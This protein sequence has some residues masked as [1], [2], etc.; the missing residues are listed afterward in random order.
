MDRRQQALKMKRAEKIRRRERLARAV[1]RLGSLQLVLDPQTRH[2]E[3]LA[4]QERTVLEVEQTVK[5][6]QE[7]RRYSNQKAN[8]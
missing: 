6:A 5:E 8:S 4:E 7:L 2:M 1:N 3:P